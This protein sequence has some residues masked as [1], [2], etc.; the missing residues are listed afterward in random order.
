MDTNKG[1]KEF[2]MRNSVIRY[3]REVS[4]GHWLLIDVSQLDRT[5]QRWVKQFLY[6]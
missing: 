4:P 6:L 5:S 3:A 1:T 2:V